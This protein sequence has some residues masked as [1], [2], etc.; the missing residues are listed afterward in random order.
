ML[1]GMP[2]SAVQ[3]NFISGNG[4]L[5]FYQNYGGSY[6]YI[7]RD[8]LDMNESAEHEINSCD[9][10]PAQDSEILDETNS[11]REAAEEGAPEQ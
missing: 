6:H 3:N 2:S 7:H 8:Y 11:G 9:L 5:H 1:F 4:H 10:N